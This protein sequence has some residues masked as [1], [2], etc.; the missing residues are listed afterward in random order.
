MI[1]QPVT[2]R[3]LLS[4]SGLALAGFQLAGTATAILGREPEGIEVRLDPAEGLVYFNEKQAAALTDLAD[5]MIPQ[6]DTPGAVASATI[7]YIDKMLP[8]WADADTKDKF[9]YMGELL[10]RLAKQQGHADYL[11]APRPVREALVENLD[12]QAFAKP[13]EPASIAYRKVKGLIFHIHYTSAQANP[14][15]VLV[16]GEYRGNLSYAEYRKLVDER[17]LQQ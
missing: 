9:A 5:I 1:K 12:E 3:I 13:S 17:K 4:R 11:A 8:D 14:D 16:P 10:D 15:Y 7:P 2:R 6:T